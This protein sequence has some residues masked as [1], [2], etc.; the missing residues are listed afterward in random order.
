MCIKRG[1]VG[2]VDSISLQ[3]KIEE[4]VSRAT[5]TGNNSTGKRKLSASSSERTLSLED[6]RSKIQEIG[7][8]KDREEK[9]IFMSD[10]VSELYFKEMVCNENFK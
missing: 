4:G 7:D 9:F 10:K 1:T 6:K 8:D 3:K 2:V 5:S